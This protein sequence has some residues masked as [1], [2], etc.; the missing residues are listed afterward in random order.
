[1]LELW[2]NYHVLLLFNIFHIRNKGVIFHGVV[3]I[4]YHT[5]TLVKLTFVQFMLSDTTNLEGVQNVYCRSTLNTSLL[6]NYY[7]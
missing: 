2:M 6:T 1:M 3:I 4:N 5:P 7:C